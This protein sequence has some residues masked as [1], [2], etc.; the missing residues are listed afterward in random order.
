MVFTSTAWSTNTKV[1]GRDLE[2]EKELFR[3]KTSNAE[4]LYST[5]TRAYWWI[6]AYHV[7]VVGDT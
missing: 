4:D 2:K 7:K 5:S 3:T 6:Y 1:F